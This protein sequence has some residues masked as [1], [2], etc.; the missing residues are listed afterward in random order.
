MLH[1]SP[2][3]GDA[4]TAPVTGEESPDIVVQQLYYMTAVPAF[5]LYTHGY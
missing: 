2:V 3:T 4:I 5:L 1:L